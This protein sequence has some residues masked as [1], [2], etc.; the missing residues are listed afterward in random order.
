MLPLATL[1]LLAITDD[2]RD[3][4]DGLVAR[5]E[6]AVAGGA[7]MVQLRLKDVDART[8]VEAARRLVATVSV[9]VIVNDRADIALA[10]GAS[11]VHL[12]A[13]DL[14]V[15]V[16]RR[17]TGEDFIIGASV[18]NDREVPMAA[19]A[20]Y[21][22]IGPVFGTPTKTDAGTAIGI[23]ELARLA[24]ACAPIP[25]VAIGGITAERAGSVIAGAG[26]A[27]VRGVAVVRAVFRAEAPDEAARA[28]RRA[29]GK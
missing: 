17:I 6:R 28:I 14:P 9:P 26:E 11:G 20:D 15:S 18:G 21:V 2:L 8:Q 24:G 7:T 4:L 3:G 10:A 13:D 1:T 22:G 16:V 19:G 27:G 29:M 5:T 25:V 12:G 23:S